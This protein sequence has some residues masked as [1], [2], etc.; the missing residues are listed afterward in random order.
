M[1]NDG[2]FLD[3]AVEM[4]MRVKNIRN[5]GKCQRKGRTWGHI[6]ENMGEEKES[7][8]CMMGSCLWEKSEQGTSGY[9]EYQ[10]EIF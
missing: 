8:A 10:R 7:F 4:E 6:I 3:A 1:V 2:K 9:Y 5:I